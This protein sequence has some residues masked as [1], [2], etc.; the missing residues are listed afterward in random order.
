MNMYAK[1]KITQMSSFHILKRTTI[2]LAFPNT[3]NR[4][5]KSVNIIT[6]E[7]FSR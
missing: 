5:I 7:D 3:I 6:L 4:Y 2:T 1:K